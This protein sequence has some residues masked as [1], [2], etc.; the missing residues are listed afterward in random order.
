MVTE[1]LPVKCS[2]CD[3]RGSVPDL[4]AAVTA[5]AAVVAGQA[6][7]SSSASNASSAHAA[8]STAVA[9]AIQ[10]MKLAPPRRGSSSSAA[11]P[12]PESRAESHPSSAAS[13]VRRNGTP[14][15]STPRSVTST[16]PPSTPA[17]ATADSSSHFRKTYDDSVAKRAIPCDNCAMTLPCRKQDP[18]NGTEDSGAADSRKPTLRTRVPC[19]RIYDGAP[20]ENSHFPHSSPSVSSSSSDTESEERP[21]SRYYSQGRHHQRTG[22]M[23]SATTSRSSTSSSASRLINSHT[24]FIDY[25]S[26]HEPT[27]VNTYY[28]I[29]AS[30][31]RTL[32]LETLPRSSV[33]SAAA[34]AGAGPA[35]HMGQPSPA[36]SHFASSPHGAANAAA[37]AATA[38]G[39]PLFFGDPTAGYTTAHV[40]RVSDVHARGHKRVYALIALSTSRERLA[41]KAF[42]FVSAAFHELATWIQQLADAEAERVAPQS[43][44]ANA[45]SRSGTNTP[46]VGAHVTGYPL[47][48][49]NAPMSPPPTQPS[50]V[51][52]DSPAS[53]GSS[54]LAAAGNGLSRRMGPG[55]AGFGGLGSS[56]ISSLRAR[57]LPEILGKPDFFIELHARFVTL[58]LELGMMLSA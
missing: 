22:T 2:T 41:M 25:T 37:A 43:E 40:F 6:V 36:M 56:S 13:S 38:N 49:P 12:E 55:Y 28:I 29:R 10:N 9:T 30:C 33:S 24:H 26:T 53:Q 16:A 11:K 17:E 48:A 42:G 18:A 47:G 23:N 4:I 44:S 8:A 39:G 20:S 27:T 7:G 34:S 54:F 21:P 32:T 46:A 19:A 52:N 35:G 1:G 31:L 45:S 58:L 3:D 5:A 50:S 15:R 14:N 57:G 51:V